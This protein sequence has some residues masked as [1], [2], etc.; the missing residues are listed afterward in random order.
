[1]LGIPLIYALVFGEFVL[2]FQKLELGKKS[3]KNTAARFGVLAVI[4]IT[5]CFT[6]RPILQ[7]LDAVTL[8][9]I[10]RIYKEQGYISSLVKEIK[11][12][13]IEQPE[14]YSVGKTVE[15]A[16]EIEDGENIVSETDKGESEESVDNTA[17]DTSETVTPKNIILIMNESLTDFE[18]VGEMYGISLSKKYSHLLA[19]RLY[20]QLQGDH[21][22]DNWMKQNHDEIE[23]MFQAVSAV[24]E[25]ESV[26]CSRIVNLIKLNLDIEADSLN[27]LFLLLD[28]KNQNQKIQGLSAAG[29]ILSHGYATASSIADAANQIIGRKVFDAIDMPLD[30][31]MSDITGLLEKHIERFITCQDVVLLVDM[32]SLEQ[33]H[34]QMGG[35]RNLNIGIINNISTALA[36]DIGLGICGNQ[37]L[38]DILKRASD[39]AGAVSKS[40][41]IR[42][43]NVIARP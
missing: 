39:S 25:K 9:Q 28:I 12:F 14:G 42:M 19:R 40:R 4:V 22:I 35:L 41:E 7:K 3:R 11:Y 27:Q 23:E 36:V 16:Q 8:W 29:I 34:S 43:L 31:Q 30:M 21:L 33:I 26:I 2:K 32:G 38:E 10:N 5:L 18:N 13:Y 6:I 15:L 17:A 37:K 1:M 24:L 20:I